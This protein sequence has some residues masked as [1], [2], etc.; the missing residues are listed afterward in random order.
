M[1]DGISDKFQSRRSRL[2]LALVFV[3]I[4]AFPA[5]LTTASAAGKPRPVE[6][7]RT[8]CYLNTQGKIGE[9]EMTVTRYSNRQRKVEVIWLPSKTTNF[10]YKG[11]SYT[12]WPHKASMQNG[13]V[14]AW[15]GHHTWWTRRHTHVAWV[16]W[17]YRQGSGPNY[18][19][20][21]YLNLRV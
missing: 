10:T 14:S 11:K 4:L 13:H 12:A 19:D 20:A 18:Y 2:V 21:C 3:G 5:A 9:A 8:S 17:G 7:Q 6:R 15:K 16:R 1:R